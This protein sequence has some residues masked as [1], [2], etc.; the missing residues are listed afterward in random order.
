MIDA[1]GWIG[2]AL[3][4]LSLTQRSMTR[5]RQLNLAASIALLLFNTALA[6]PSMV[7]LNGV[8]VAV[9]VYHLGKARR[10]ASLR[11]EE[12]VD[13]GEELAPRRL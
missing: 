13:A 7:L 5:L 2:S 9:N 3:I 6:I 4:A 12:L 11:R 8:L 10:V 1:L